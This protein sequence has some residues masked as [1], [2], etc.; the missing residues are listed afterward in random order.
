MAPNDD[1]EVDV[2]DLTTY[3]VDSKFAPGASTKSATFSP[4]GRYLITGDRT[5]AIMVWDRVTQIPIELPGINGTAH[6]VAVSPD[7]KQLAEAGSDGAVK[8]WDLTKIDDKT[9]EWKPD[10]L[11]QHA[12]P[13]YGLAYS[14]DL[15]NPRLATSGWDGTV[16]IWNPQRKEQLRVL[17]GHDGDVFGV[18]FGQGG[19]VVASAS[20]DGTVRVWDV[21]SGKEL[22]VFR[23]GGRAFH[24]VRFSPDGTTLVAGSRDGAVRAWDVK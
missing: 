8:L 3:K 22:H 10:S 19:K 5:G 16:R 11:E 17:K 9:K 4:D 14:P 20:A 21:E 12:G 13:V 6:N 2:Y 15:A 7:S 18:S 23:G 1:N 24:T